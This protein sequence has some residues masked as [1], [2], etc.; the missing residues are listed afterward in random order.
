MNH[1]DDIYFVHQEFDPDEFYRFLEEAEGH[2]R[3]IPGVGRDLPQY[4]IQKL[5]LNRDPLESRSRI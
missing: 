1:F 3:E 5:G 2:A 4:I